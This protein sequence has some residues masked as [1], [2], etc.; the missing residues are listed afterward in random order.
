M[1]FQF[2]FPCTET[3][4]LAFEKEVVDILS[5]IVG[6]SSDAMMLL[7]EFHFCIHESI[8]NILQHTYKW[9]VNQK[10]EVKISVTEEGKNQVCEVTIRDFGPPV[11]QKLT[12]PA[13]VDKFQIRKRGLYMMSKILDNFSLTP[14]ADG[15]ITYLKK[16][17]TENSTQD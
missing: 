13:S 6:S 9:N 3:E 14:L 11:P 5:R 15:N 17:F 8:L 2:T 16:V 10:L 12:P 4:I 1:I 7:H